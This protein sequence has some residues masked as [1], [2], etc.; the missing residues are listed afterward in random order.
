MFI[1]SSYLPLVCP[2]PTMF[3]SKT[4][5]RTWPPM[6]RVLCTPLLPTCSHYGT[7]L[8]CTVHTSGHCVMSTGWNICNLSLNENIHKMKID[9]L[10]KFLMGEPN[11]MVSARLSCKFPQ[12]SDLW[13][14]FD[15]CFDD[16]TFERKTHNLNRNVYSVDQNK[17]DWKQFQSWIRFF[18]LN[19]SC[20]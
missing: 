11:I 18:L 12:V 6:Y 16:C 17:N 1:C 3:T 5:V 8:L 2:A 20:I 15:R 14:W 4:L 7:S 10:A 13:D 19:F 9:I